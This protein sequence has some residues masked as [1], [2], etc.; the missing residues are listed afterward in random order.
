MIIT[1][2]KDALKYLDEKIIKV[3]IDE[4]IISEND[5]LNN[6]KNAK[7]ILKNFGIDGV[8]YQI[9]IREKFD[10]NLDDK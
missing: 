3:K 9:K 6:I 2:P 5:R 7:G 10:R 1:L 8:E 4:K